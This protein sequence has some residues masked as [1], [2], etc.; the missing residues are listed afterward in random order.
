MSRVE[1]SGR[2][3]SLVAFNERQLFHDIAGKNYPSPF[4]WKIDS[5]VQILR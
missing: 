5:G 3:K 1:R 2:C 4:V